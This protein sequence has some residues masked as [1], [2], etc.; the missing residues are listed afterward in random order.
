VYAAG[1]GAGALAVPLLLAGIAW[2]LARGGLPTLTAGGARGAWEFLTR[3]SWDPVR[4]AFGVGPAL[5]GTLVT[6]ALALALAAPLGL[7]AAVYTAELAPPRLRAP[8][9]ALVD[10]LAAVPS[11]VYGLWG[12]QVLVPAVRGHVGPLLRDG[13]GLGRFGAFAGPA[14]GPSVLAASL[15]L[16]VMVLPYVAAVSREVLR[17]V[18]AAQREAAL[19]LGATPWEAAVGVVL[20]H[21]RAGV[22]GAVL[23]GLGRALGETM[24]VAMVIGAAHR[25]P[26]SLLAPGYTLAALLANEFAEAGDDR[27]L[28]AL[29]AA[30]LA[31]FAVTL[32]VNAVARRLVGSVADG[33]T[34]HPEAGR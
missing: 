11:V 9:A 20:P 34:D 21:A 31:L 7:A 17:A 29:L 19:A 32:V 23:L 28:A 18:P 2:A 16:A 12:L 5:A 24:A 15:V 4:G 1:I 27:H 8:L 3:A 14:H 6:A 25:G 13:L 22:A 30:G 33:E 26:G 10:L